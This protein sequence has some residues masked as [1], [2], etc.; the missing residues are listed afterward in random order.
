MIKIKQRTKHKYRVRG[1]IIA[2]KKIKIN[3]FF[4]AGRVKM[5]FLLVESIKLNKKTKKNLKKIKL[6]NSTT[7]QQQIVTILV[8]E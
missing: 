7:L 4:I 8:F 6:L 3:L 5:V 1:K 2:M